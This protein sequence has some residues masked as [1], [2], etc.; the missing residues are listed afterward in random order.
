MSCLCG[1]YQAS[2]QSSAFSNSRCLSSSRSLSIEALVPQGLL[3]SK[4]R[5]IVAS[6]SERHP[7]ASE[8]FCNSNIMH[9]HAAYAYPVHLSK[10]SNYAHEFVECSSH[11]LRGDICA[12]ISLDLFWREHGITFR[13]MGMSMPVLPEWWVVFQHLKLT[14]V[15]KGPLMDRPAEHFHVQPFIWLPLPAF[16]NTSLT[17]FND[18]KHYQWWN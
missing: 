14:C 5:T 10:F 8:H 11:P 12:H 15:A 13:Q 3:P 18:I 9:Q 7:A 6:S 4:Q 1:V 2:P 16:L 17:T